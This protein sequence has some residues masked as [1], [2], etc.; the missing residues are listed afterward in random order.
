MK[1]QHKPWKTSRVLAALV[2]LVAP[3]LSARDIEPVVGRHGMV[4]AGHPEAAEIGLDILRQGGNAMDAAVATSFALGV[5]EPYGSGIGG[6]CVILYFESKTGETRYIDG[7]DAAGARLDVE[8]LSQATPEERAEGGLGVAVPGQVAAMHLAHQNWGQLPWAD[9][10]EPSAALA[11][12]GFLVVSGMPVFFERRLERIR[13]NAEARRLYL[14]DDA[15]PAEGERLANADLARTI[16][17]IAETGR[18]GFYKGAIAESIVAAVRDQGGDLTLEDLETYEAKILEPIQI[19]WRDRK[20][21]SSPPPVKGGATALLVMKLL[22]FHGWPE[23]GALRRPGNIDDW[24]RAFRHVYP[25]IEERMGD[26]PEAE[27]NWRLLVRDFTLQQLRQEIL[28]NG[29]PPVA[30]S[31]RPGEADECTTHFVVADQY[32]NV[33]SV[34]QSLSHHFG[35]GVIALEGPNAPARGRR[36]TSTI[37]PVIVL[38]DGLPTLALGLPG[39]Q[40]IPTTLALVLLDRMAFGVPIGEAIIAP[41]VHLKR[42]YS[43]EPDSALIQLEEPLTV[44]DSLALE[45]EGWKLEVPANSGYFGG[46]TA[47]EIHEDGTLTGWAD[48]RR[49]NAAAG[50]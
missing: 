25:L 30:A 29:S 32:G 6:K 47:I 33:A 49:T 3:A 42:S 5:A 27:A 21:V 15:I 36:P 40:R 12:N 43:D 50:F 1:Q 2:L 28:R 39:G 11:E 9:L 22:E 37:A 41:R 35:S 19:D 20:I 46:I 24:G 48:L 17:S 38:K 44:A 16:R 4:V 8:K 7:L 34:T 23:R 13:S 31:F 26:H 10:L 14:V 18:D 45:S